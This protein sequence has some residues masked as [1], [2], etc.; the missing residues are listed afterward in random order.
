M[1]G[2]EAWCG[3]HCF[4]GGYLG[5]SLLVVVFSLSVLETAPEAGGKA[6]VGE[7]CC[8]LVEHDL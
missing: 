8:S 3:W 6:S 5:L 7:F 2:G 4:G 1:A